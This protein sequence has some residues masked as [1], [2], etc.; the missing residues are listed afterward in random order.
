MK[1]G[2]KALLLISILI[3]LTGVL[4]AQDTSISAKQASQLADFI[5][6]S[7]FKGDYT[8]ADDGRIFTKLK[9][10]FNLSVPNDSLTLR[11]NADKIVT[12]LYNIYKSNGANYSLK[13]NSYTDSTQTCQY[14]QYWNQFFLVHQPYYLLIVYHPQINSYS[15][16]NKLYMKPVSIP[17]KVISKQT[18]QTMFDMLES[19]TNLNPDINGVKKEYVLTNTLKTVYYNTSDPD[20]IRLEI[21]LNLYPDKV[22]NQ[23]V[24]YKLMWKTGDEIDNKVNLID[25][26]KGEL[27]EALMDLLQ[28]KRP[29]IDAANWF[30][31]NI[32]VSGKVYAEYNEGGGRLSFSRLSFSDIKYPDVVIRDTEAMH[33]EADKF[34]P[35]LLEMYK[36]FG[37]TTA[38]DYVRTSEVENDGQLIFLSHYKQKFRFPIDEGASVIGFLVGYNSVEKYFYINTNIYTKP[39]SYPARVVSPKAILELAGYIQV[40][41]ND[42]SDDTTKQI[43]NSFTDISLI[44]ADNRYTDSKTGFAARL[45]LF[46]ASPDEMLANI[47]LMWQVSGN[48]NRYKFDPVTGMPS[49]Y[50]D[51]REYAKEKDKK[52][53]IPDNITEEDIADAFKPI[54]FTGKPSSE[55]VN[56]HYFEASLNLPIP[57]DA[58][59]FTSNCVTILSC[60]MDLHKISVLDYS[61]KAGRQDSLPVMTF[62]IFYKDIFLAGIQPN[63][64]IE[65]NPVDIYYYSSTNKYMVRDYISYYLSSEIESLYPDCLISPLSACN[66]TDDSVP[67]IWS[68]ISDI[69]SLDGY[70]YDNTPSGVKIRLGYSNDGDEPQ[71]IHLLFSPIEINDDGTKLYEYKLVWNVDGPK[72]SSLVINAVTGEIVRYYAAD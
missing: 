10:T 51:R 3:G 53:T 64:N 50:S 32:H 69:A 38:V 22:N 8:P 55:Y 41:G 33:R 34:I 60:L 59:Q 13:C 12:E 26:E 68:E 17:D 15:V 21:A 6:R 28:K 19:N 11:Q 4:Y 70:H 27:S 67:L 54:G 48:N 23:I 66:M 37:F 44:P 40:K 46:P 58:E 71:N 18:A 14:V 1:Q 63:E 65:Q 20:Y 2:L 43:I 56:S 5:T 39:I 61:F 29:F 16:Y 62:N 7:G 31:R 42:I 72:Y 9:G 47:Y 49:G 24:G 35:T 52:T 30:I 45:M 57:A 36:V 25:A